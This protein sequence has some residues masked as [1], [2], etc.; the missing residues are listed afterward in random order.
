MSTPGHERYLKTPVGD[1]LI[2]AT[3]V[4]L[5]ALSFLAYRTKDGSTED[6][7]LRGEIGSS[8]NDDI[9]HVASQLAR[10]FDGTLTQFDLD[11]DLTGVSDFTRR[12]LQATGL[13]PYGEV[14]T[15]GEVATMIGSH[16]STQAVGNALGMNPIPIVIPCHRVIRS[17]GS[18][19]S[20]TGGVYIKRALLDIEGVHFPEQQTLNL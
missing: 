2:S 19:G 20:Y 15:Y 17:D 8:D 11:I 7:E 3:P 4:G 10:Y 9:G 14:R 5:S 1:V 12:V 6:V 13:I 16:G 18:M